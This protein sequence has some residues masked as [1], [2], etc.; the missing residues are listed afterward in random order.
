[1]DGAHES[2]TSH[3]RPLSSAHLFGPRSFDWAK[4]SKTWLHCHMTA[5]IF[6]LLAA[7][8]VNLPMTNCSPFELSRLSQRQTWTSASRTLSTGHWIAF[9]V[10]S[11]TT[12]SQS[13]RQ[14]PL[15]CQLRIFCL[16][17]HKGQIE[18]KKSR[19]GDKWDLCSRLASVPTRT[20]WK[21][22]QWGFDPPATLTG[23]SRFTDVD[24][25]KNIFGNLKN[26]FGN[27]K[28]IFG[29]LNSFNLI[30]FNNF[31]K[32]WFIKID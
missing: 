31:W 21:A 2:V 24:Y 17:P 12:D 14:K 26:L 8:G 3:D 32:F 4:R 16:R 20:G 10:T 5:A 15:V 1:M 23:F 22:L 9:D 19:H 11:W 6:A 30:Q 28:N 18:K 27:L 29:N 13:R 7:I 25:W